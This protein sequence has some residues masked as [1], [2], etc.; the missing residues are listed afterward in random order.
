MKLPESNKLPINKLI[1]CFDDTTNSYKY[2]WFLS[3]LDEVKNS[4]GNEVII[5]TDRLVSRMISKTWFTLNYYKLSFGKLDRFSKIVESIKNNTDLK[6]DDKEDKVFEV[7]SEFYNSRRSFLKKENLVLDRYVKYRFL[8]P[9][10][11]NELR[12]IE[13]KD[14]EIKRLAQK[15]ANNPAYFPIYT[16]VD[17]K[18]NYIKISPYW[19]KYLRVNNTI[20]KAF[21]FWHLTNYLQSKNPNVPNI[22]L[23][24]FPPIERDLKLAKKFWS[25]VLK[26]RGVIR[27]IY[28]GQIIDRI[29]TIDHFIPWSFVAHDKL[30]NLIPTIK[31]VNS[32]KSDNLPSLKK[33]FE[34]FSKLQYDSVKTIINHKVS[35]KML[36]DYI[37]LFNYNIEYI[38]K[39]DYNEFK[40]KLKET[41]TPLYQIAINTGFNSDWELNT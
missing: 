15:Y 25:L 30:W 34:K 11:K 33:Y 35:E 17:S 32:A 31:K 14:P 13:P 38:A 39:I 21:C 41:I 9:W 7:I 12:G 5:P 10:F 26:N 1:Q 19:I 18:S 8:T 2:Y 29:F 27:C 3:I 16:F 6:I 22:T 4:V 40:L 24:L 37:N 20:L 28:S 36:E 23:K